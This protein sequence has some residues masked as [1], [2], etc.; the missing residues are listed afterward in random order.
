M[1]TDDELRRLLRACEGRDFDARRDLAIIRLLLDSG[2]RR[3]ECA[4]LSVTDVDFEHN[5][6]LVLGKGRRHR[7]C[8]FGKKTALALDRYLRV[9]AAPIRG[10]GEPV[11]GSSGGAEAGRRLRCDQEA[12]R[13]GR[14]RPRPSFS[15]G[16]DRL[17]NARPRRLNTA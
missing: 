10:P 5:V 4:G 6:V 12:D 13:A 9:C 14:H 2:I 3:A 11:A 15:A 7:A 17:P 8:P 16:P 1:L